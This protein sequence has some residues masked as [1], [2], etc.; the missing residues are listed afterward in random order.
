[1][2]KSKFGNFRFDEDS[3][4]FSDSDFAD[5]AFWD[6]FWRLETAGKEDAPL[7][8]VNIRDQE[9]GEERE[10]KNV[11]LKFRISTKLRD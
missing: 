8:T 2:A 5:Q 4:D 3:F 11:R 6:E 7:V 10:I 9:T 1:M